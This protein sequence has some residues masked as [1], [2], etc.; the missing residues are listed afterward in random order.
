MHHTA[1]CFW[2][3]IVRDIWSTTECH[4]YKYHPNLC[5]EGTMWNKQ[6]YLTPMEYLQL[7]RATLNNSRHYSKCC[8]E[9][10]HAITEQE[11]S[12]ERNKDIQQ[13]VLTEMSVVAQLLRYS[14]KFTEIKVYYSVQQ[15]TL[16]TPLPILWQHNNTLLT[17]YSIKKH[18]EKITCKKLCQ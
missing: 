16:R 6:K 14:P 4:R 5:T 3:C 7:W 12:N 13:T 17:N 2:V 9:T 8:I 10:M 15:N 1:V 18:K 11:L